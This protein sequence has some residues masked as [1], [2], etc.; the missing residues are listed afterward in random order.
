M[1][2]KLNLNAIEVKSYVT[3][4]DSFNKETVKGG[5][6]TQDTGLGMCQCNATRTC[7]V[8]QKSEMVGG[9]RICIIDVGASQNLGNLYIC[10]VAKVA[11]DDILG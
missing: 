6:Q 9:V 5:A 4:L 8:E 3:S 7:Y 11:I 1:K 2:K 10:G